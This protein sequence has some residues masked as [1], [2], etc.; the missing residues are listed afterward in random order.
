MEN[1]TRQFELEDTAKPILFK[2]K[3]ESEEKI[4]QRE[5]FLNTVLENR[6]RLY[7]EPAKVNV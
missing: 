6:K 1:L 4:Q 7:I 2:S 3:E 5:K